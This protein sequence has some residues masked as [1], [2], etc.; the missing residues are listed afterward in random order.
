MAGV[1]VNTAAVMIGSIIGLVFNK[2]IP[3]RLTKSIMA[4]IGLC[5]L[6]IGISGALKDQNTVVMILSVAV[7]AIIGE[8][9]DI[10]KKLTKFAEGMEQRFSREGTQVSVTEGFITASLL[11]CIGAMTVVGSLQA[12]MTGNQ[13]MLYTKSVLDFISSIVFS[14]SL[15][16]GVLL[17]AGFV[18]VF[19]GTLV[20]FSRFLAPFLTDYAIAEMTAVGSLLIIALGFNILGITKIKVANYIPA[21]FAAVIFCFFL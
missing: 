5:T 15:G 16:I 10:D 18:L 12:G 3:E 4:G 2:G 14:A 13:E 21:V 17:S 19:Q 9:A 1:L 6:Y 11:F 8:W 20:L 7:G